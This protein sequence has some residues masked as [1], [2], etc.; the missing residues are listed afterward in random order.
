MSGNREITICGV[1]T[2][3]CSHVEA[4]ELLAGRLKSLVR[5]L[6]P[7][8]LL[9]PE[10]WILNRYQDDSA[11]LSAI[12]SSISDLS[13]YRGTV[14]V[15][16]SFS[17]FRNGR[18]YNTSPVIADGKLIGWSDKI[19][20]YRREKQ[21]YTA[22][23]EVTVFKGKD[24]KFSIPVCYDL[25]FPYFAKVAIRKGARLL[26]NPSLIM[27]DFHSMW[28]IYVLAR[29]LE[30]RIPVVSI[31]ASSTPLLGGSIAT[32]LHEEEGGVIIEKHRP[33]SSVITYTLDMD[34]TIPLIERR[35][36]E[37]PGSYSL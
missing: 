12:I 19:S 13:E 27:K 36:E 15:P 14:I 37:D 23:S 29:S 33:K 26:L 6:S 9:L 7:D 5:K 25:D 3:L 18:L 20:L 1:E 16:G 17:I 30:N 8:F 32:S 11:D 31:N 28:H 2:S 21:E 35:M 10:K 24:I 4:L 34:A 22:G